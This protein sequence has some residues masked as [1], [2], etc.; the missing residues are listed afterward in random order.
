MLIPVAGDVNK[1][2]PQT[3]VFFMSNNN[4]TFIV[5]SF[6]RGDVKGEASYLKSYGKMEK[7]L[8]SLRH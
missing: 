8:P 1:L 7:I 3:A 2:C 4:L 5:R 6:T